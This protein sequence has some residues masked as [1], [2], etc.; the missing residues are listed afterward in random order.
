[1]AFGK[2][3]VFHSIFLCQ[4]SDVSLLVRDRA[5]VGIIFMYL[6]LIVEIVNL[7]LGIYTKTHF[8][9]I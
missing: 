6:F 4:I 8:V 1:M 2:C 9:D 7:S 5:V 3:V